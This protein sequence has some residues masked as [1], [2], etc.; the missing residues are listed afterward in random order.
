[1]KAT[2][3]AKLRCGACK[4]Q[5]VRPG[6]F[7]FFHVITDVLYALDTNAHAATG[8]LAQ[9]FHGAAGLAEIMS[10]DPE[11]FKPQPWSS[12]TY[13]CHGCAMKT[14]PGEEVESEPIKME[15]ARR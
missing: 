11:V 15:D 7:P 9:M 13:L 6:E 3:F 12:R 1:M 14:L 4:K 5:L 8:G 10:P 2:E